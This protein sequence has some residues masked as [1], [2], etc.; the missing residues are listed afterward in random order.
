MV[1]VLA[2]DDD[3]Q[4]VRLVQRALSDEGH[5]VLAA[6]SAGEAINL[7]RD[8]PVDLVVLDINLP[9]A[10]GIEVC[11]Y[12]RT[13]PH[14]AGVRIL[15][16][17][18]RVEVQ[19][20][21]V[22]FEAGG[23]D[24]LGKPFFAQELVYRVRALVRTLPADAA[25]RVLSV[26]PVRIDPE[27]QSV[28]VQGVPVQLTPTELKLLHYL[29]AHSGKVI[30]ALQ[31]LE[32]VWGYPPGVGSGNLVRMHILNLRAKIEVDPS[33]PKLLRTLPKHGYAFCPSS[34][35]PLL[36]VRTAPDRAPSPQPPATSDQR[37]GRRSVR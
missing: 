27:A 34:D 13:H 6:Y 30:S 29:V 7:L 32:R 22:G 4:V 19:D 26:G 12:I 17:T 10:S 2:V 28:Q 36:E 21:I 20:R 24:Y 37:G 18:Q 8:E 14:V 3:K 31:L 11:K 16:L 23:D 33:R 15:F 25:E 1:Q 9:D 5:A 35:A